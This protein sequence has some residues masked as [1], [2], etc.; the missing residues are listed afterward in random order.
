MNLG[1]H[2]DFDLW[3]RSVSALSYPPVDRYTTL[4]ARL[5]WKPRK[6]LEVA[7]VGQ[8]LLNSSHLEY[9][10]VFSNSATTEVQRGVYARIDWRF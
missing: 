7:I 3:L 5:S 9:G 6:D 2:L 4:D 10:S 1:D 8:N